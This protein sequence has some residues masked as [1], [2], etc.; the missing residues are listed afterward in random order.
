[1]SAN[2]SFATT[3][4]TLTQF[5]AKQKLTNGAITSDLS[6]T[7][8][9]ITANVPLYI[10]RDNNLKTSTMYMTA[11]S[12]SS[13]GYLFAS[14]WT[15]FNNKLTS[16]T[17]GTNISSTSGTSPTVSLSIS[18]NLDMSNNLIK[19]LSSQDY[20]TEIDI[21]QANTSRIYTSGGLMNINPLRNLTIL[22]DV[23]LNGKKIDMVSGV[24]TGISNESF[25]TNIDIRQGVTK[26]IFTTTGA[27]PSMTLNSPG[28]LIIMTDVSLNAN[29]LDMGGGIIKR[30]S[31]QDFETIIDIK[32]AGTSRISTSSGIM[33]INPLNNLT[34]TSDVSLNG[35]RLDM[36]NGDI[37]G[38]SNTNFN[39]EI[40]IK[41]ANTSRIYTSGGILNINP[42]RNLTILTDVSLNGKRLDMVNGDISGI[43]N[44][45]FN[46][47]IDIKQANTSRIYTS[48]GILNINPLRNVT[49]LSDISLNGKRLDMVNGDISGILNTNF[50]TEIDIKQANTSRIYTSGGI[51]NINPLRNLTILSD[52]SLN[53]KRLDM[54]NGDISGILNTNFKTEIDIKQAGTSRIYTSSS[55]MKINPAGILQ[56]LSDI[57]SNGNVIFNSITSFDTGNV[58]TFDTAN[59]HVGYY[60][61]Y[62]FSSNVMK[63]NV[64]APTVNSSTFNISINKVFNNIT[65]TIPDITFAFNNNTKIIN[66]IPA[67]DASYSPISDIYLPAIV[68]NNNVISNTCGKLKIT[69][70]GLMYLYNTFNELLDW[71]GNLVGPI[72]CGMISQCFTYSIL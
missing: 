7:E 10:S 65:L 49:I 15:A 1:M 48:G 32:E 41:Q 9:P 33:T 3:T 59:K 19:N 56:I 27:N 2:T 47:E 57:S 39:T 46:T 60:P 43:S 70:S 23:S 13:D 20:K 45:N 6:S 36:V 69:T 66:I 53:G 21:K 34:I 63:L 24:I 26:R 38:I 71:N 11:S 18:S 17:A 55:D 67:I 64:T 58:L 4:S 50:K 35:K 54:V 62:D 42:L 51:M 25:I 5:I 14:K 52:I 61:F 31:E 12:A 44:T 16:I 8:Y 29:T 40:D 28:N 68:Y 22:S 30:V 72:K 37:S